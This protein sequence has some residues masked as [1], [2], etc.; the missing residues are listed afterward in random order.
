MNNRNKGVKC[1]AYTIKLFFPQYSRTEFF[2]IRFQIANNHKVP[3]TDNTKNT[4]IANNGIPMVAV[5]EGLLY[6]E[7]NAN[8]G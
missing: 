4:G 8:N 7:N 1:N 3:E 5:K 6:K 2:S